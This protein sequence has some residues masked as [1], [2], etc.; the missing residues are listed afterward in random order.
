MPSVGETV[1]AAVISRLRDR[2]EI[3]FHDARSRDTVHVIDLFLLHLAR[4]GLE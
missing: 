1:A 3:S 2:P 4:A